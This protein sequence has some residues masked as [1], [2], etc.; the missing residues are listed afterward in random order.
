MSFPVANQKKYYKL[1]EKIGTLLSLRSK[2]MLF[3]W[4][5]VIDI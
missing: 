5:F 4:E 3:L 1:K 2:S